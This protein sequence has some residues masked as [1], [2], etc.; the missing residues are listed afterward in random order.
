[1]KKVFDKDI[2]G[3]NYAFFRTPLLGEIVYNVS[4]SVEDKSIVFLMR[5]NPAGWSIVQQNDLPE[6]VYQSEPSI[7]DTL[8]ENENG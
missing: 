5:K 2:N 7:N 4:L 1:M 6:F 3:I 8:I